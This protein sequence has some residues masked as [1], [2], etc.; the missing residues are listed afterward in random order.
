M[1]P[2]SRCRAGLWRRRP[3]ERELTAY[4]EAGHLVACAALGGAV[5]GGR[6]LP[7]G[8]RLSGLALGRVGDADDWGELTMVAAGSIAESHRW[9]TGD[10]LRK[11]D[12]QPATPVPELSPLLDSIGDD[13]EVPSDTERLRDGMKLLGVDPDQPGGVLDRLVRETTR[14]VRLRWGSIEAVALDLLAEGEVS[15]ER[16][17]ELVEGDWMFREWQREQA[18][19]ERRSRRRLAR[20]LGVM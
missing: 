19:A 8:R 7:P 2:W 4:H 15:G 10:R 1:T 5:R 17:R 12:P 3:T 14:L 9:P 18:E 11:P 20:L 13:P 16:V 6:L